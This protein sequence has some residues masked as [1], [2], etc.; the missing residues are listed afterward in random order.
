[1]AGRERR[2]YRRWRPGARAWR[3][4][5]KKRWAAV[6]GGGN[7]GRRRGVFRQP[8]G[9]NY[10]FSAGLIS[11]E[12][13][14]WRYRG[15]TFGPGW[16]HAPGPKAFGPDACDEPGPKSFFWLPL[17]PNHAK[18]PLVPVRATNRDQ[19]SIS[20]CLFKLFRFPPYFKSKNNIWHI[21]MFRKEISM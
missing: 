10:S 20:M 14:W 16:S 21:K 8:G 18:H 7:G 15:G 9:V 12:M 3:E 6:G 5:T 17:F 13:K 4:R 11:A 1:V 19:R 2:A